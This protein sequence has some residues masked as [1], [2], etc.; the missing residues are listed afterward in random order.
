MDDSVSD[1]DFRAAQKGAAMDFLADMTI[2][3]LL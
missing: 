2:L 3:S 1:I